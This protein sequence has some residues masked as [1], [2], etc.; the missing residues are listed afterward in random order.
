MAEYEIMVCPVCLGQVE[1][2]YEQPT[3]HYHEDYVGIV[4]PVTISAS[5]LAK[6]LSEAIEVAQPKLEEQRQ[7][8]AERRKKRAEWEALPK[9]ERER[10]KAERW[11]KMSTMEKALYEQFGQ[12]QADLIDQLGRQAYGA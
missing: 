3:G 4:K 5:V 2:E 1:P 6:K 12:S 7:E 8:E 10:I 9:E 11:A